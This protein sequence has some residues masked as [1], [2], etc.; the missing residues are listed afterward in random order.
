[1]HKHIASFSS[2]PAGQP[3]WLDVLALMIECEQFCQMAEL[4]FCW[5]NGDPDAMVLMTYHLMRSTA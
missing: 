4:L 5:I 2:L 3:V 1:M